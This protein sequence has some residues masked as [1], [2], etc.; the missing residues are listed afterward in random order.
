MREFCKNKGL[1]FYSFCFLRGKFMALYY[2][3]TNSGFRKLGKSEISFKSK[4]GSELAEIVVRSNIIL[5]VN[6]I[7]QQGLTIRTLETLLS[8]KKM[9]T[10]NSDIKRYDFY[11][12]ANICIVDRNNIDI[13]DTFLQSKYHEVPEEILVKYTAKGWV[14]D[15]FR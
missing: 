2:M 14:D 13:P 1:R 12:S 8:K 5:D 15:V 11:N 10:T 6:D 9:I 7:K 3:L 4:P